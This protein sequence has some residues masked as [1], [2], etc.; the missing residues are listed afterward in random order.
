MGTD[1]LTRVNDILKREI[2][3]T[4]YQ[5]VREDGFDLSAVTITRVE[6]VRD[7]R[8][9]R[10][11]VS[12]RDYETRAAR[13]LAVLRR[14]RVEIQARINR[15]LGLRH[16]PRLAFALDTSVA[17]GDNVLRILS[18]IE[19]KGPAPDAAGGGS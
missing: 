13:V 18:E 14:H 1:R 4:L 8:S 5:V 12:V 3:E 2:A 7:L 16:T 17:R 11:L 19:P 6:A 15:D 10:V 9:A